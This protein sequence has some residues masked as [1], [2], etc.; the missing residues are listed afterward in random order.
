MADGIGLA[1]AVPRCTR[2][3][4]R[5][6]RADGAF[7]EEIVRDMAAH[8]DRPV[9]LPMSNPTELAEAAPADLIRWTDGR[10]LVAAG[11]PDRSG[12]LQRVTT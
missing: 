7:T 9:I 10:A 1:E 4:H 2:R 6:L 5:H 12:Q 11:S 8:V 3:P